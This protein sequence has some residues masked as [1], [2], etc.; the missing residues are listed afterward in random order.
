MSKGTLLAAA[1]AVVLVLAHSPAI[2][3]PRAGGQVAP[4]DYRSADRWVDSA[5]PDPRAELIV[6]VNVVRIYSE[7]HTA[8]QIAPDGWV[9]TQLAIANRVYRFADAD[10]EAF[11]GGRFAPVIQ[12]QH[13]KT[14][15]VHEREVSETLG[16]EMDTE[17]VYGAPPDGNGPR[18]V[19]T[20]DLRTLK[21]TDEVDHLTVFCVWALKDPTHDANEIGGESNVGF[22]DRP[23]TGPRR[24]LTRV[25]DVRAR[26]GVVTTRAEGAWMNNL[27]HEI[28]H[29]FGL[30]HAW[31]R[32]WNVRI[33]CN[34]LGLG[35]QGDVDQT[36]GFANV[37]DYENGDG[38]VQY[39]TL[40]QI[41]F[42]YRFA[43]D[44]ASTQILVRRQ[45]TGAPPPA[46]RVAAFGPATA[47]PPAPGGDI[48]VRFSLDASGFRG[49]PVNLVAWFAD[50]SGQRIED[51]DGQFRTFDGQVSVGD[52]VT[53][54]QDRERLENLRLVLPAGQT[55]LPPG[56]HRLQ[57]TLGAFA[58]GESLA[59]GGPVYLTYV[60]PGATPVPGGEEP[61]GVI[62]AT[63]VDP[64]AEHQGTTYVKIS[65]NLQVDNLLGKE[66]ALQARYQF[67]DGTPLKDFDGQWVSSDGLAY[68]ENK[69][70]PQYVRTTVTGM[71]V[72][73][74]VAQLHLA[75]GAW[76]VRASLTLVGGGR[77]LASATTDVFRLG[78]G[79]PPP[80][81]P[82]AAA[83][84]EQGYVTHDVV[85][86]GQNGMLLRA[87]MTITGLR[88][89]EV[90][91][92]AWYWGADGQPLKDFDGAYRSGSG[93]VCAMLNVT[94]LYDV[95]IF[96]DLTVF[97]PY[98]QLHLAPGL[99]PLQA[100]LEA[101]VGGKGIGM[102]PAP[103]PFQVMWR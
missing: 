71:E 7:E 20:T 78:Q 95:A 99:Q 11:G 5:P 24:V 72:W 102:T 15:D 23:P 98:A 30:P 37:M 69:V 46:A 47:D 82:A 2:A 8:A 13:H 51:T 49:Q 68:A 94:P 1:L 100:T 16:Y 91:V 9:A 101:Y 97:I 59:S 84:F 33:G 22:A 10:M 88:G 17:N 70:V 53:P 103:I 3:V 39:F 62:T 42:M 26:L 57:V 77:A 44:K 43:R 55:H 29:F 6:P 63:A 27:A 56:T 48:V 65:A 67:A 45:G 86:D 35:A 81:V 28:G 34:D 36:P 85:I 54:T 73:I 31:M 4:Q 80:P 52:N 79:A 58:G 96:P 89:T 38:V 83:V 50:G 32:D 12:F 90:L 25:S 41:D 40:T 93:Q 61:A 14:Y 87:R 19:G 21:V 75:E 18:R 92:A 76:D 64:A 74:P 66:V 60:V